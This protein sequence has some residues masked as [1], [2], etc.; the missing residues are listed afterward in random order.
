MPIGQTSENV[1]IDL[2]VPVPFTSHDSTR[3]G[4]N[5]VTAAAQMKKWKEVRLALSP[6]KESL[7]ARRESNAGNESGAIRQS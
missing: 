3:R 2:P 6:R 4:D 7:S 5:A 1:L